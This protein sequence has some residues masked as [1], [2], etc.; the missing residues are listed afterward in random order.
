MFRRIRLPTILLGL[1]LTGTA[2]FAQVSQASAPDADKPSRFR[3]AEDGWFDVSGFLDEAYGFLPIVMPITEPAV[4]FGAVAALAFLDKPNPEAGAGFGRPNITMVGGLGTDNGS[5]G[6]IAGDIRYWLDDRVQ[7]LIGGIKSTINLDYYGSGEAGFRNKHPRT[8]ALDVEAALL[9]AKMRIG[10]SQNWVGLGYVLAN[11]GVNFD[12]RLDNS[13]ELRDPERSLRLG[14]ILASLSHDSRDNV[15]TPREGN[16]LELSAAIFRPGTGSDL[17]FTRL[18]L[19]GMHY[20]PLASRWTL[21]LREN[22]AFNYGDAPF[23]LQP[24]VM[25]RGVPAMRYQGEKVAQIEAEVRWQFWERFSLVGFAGAG[26]AAE[27]IREL[28]RTEGITAGGVGI[29]YE[30]A[31]KYGI[32]MGL[33]AAWSRDEPAVYFQVGSAWMRP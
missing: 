7:T 18:T 3:S 13:F 16:Y 14:G 22:L 27:A 24:F 33:D 9:Q 31:R 19:V 11:T 20:L 4:G 15:F 28:T 30:I 17:D 12:S 29:R 6:L 25:M 32:H 8:Y 21:G 23:Y 10:Q 2:A 5:R 26:W 1:L